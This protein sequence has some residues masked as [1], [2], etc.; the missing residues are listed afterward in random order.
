MR[1]ALWVGI[2]V[3]ATFIGSFFLAS[4]WLSQRE[5]SVP[6]TLKVDDLLTRPPVSSEEVEVYVPD[7]GSKIKNQK[8]KRR[9][10]HA[11]RAIKKHYYK[12]IAGVFK[13][14]SSAQTQITS[15][16]NK[17]FESFIKRTRHGYRVQVGAY[18][19]LAEA[20]TLQAK[21]KESGFES[22]VVRE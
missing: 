20:K 17:E 2:L 1:T 12:V 6:P 13:N 11:A 5:V 18:R 15:L 21:L 16:K 9:T 8:S 10:S 22:Y 19:S 14:K 3:I 4:Q 7:A